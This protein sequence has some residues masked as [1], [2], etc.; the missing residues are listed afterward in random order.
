[1]L[2]PSEW[3]AGP[4]VSLSLAGPCVMEFRRDTAREGLFLPPRSLLVMAEE[5]RYAWHHYIPHRRSDAVGGRVIPR[6]A[7]RVSLT[8]RKV[9]VCSAEVDLLC[10]A[11]AG[12]PLVGH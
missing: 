8:F 4:I 12:S 1:M 2:Y 5:A 11:G 6:A 10:R 7:K 3:C 9:P